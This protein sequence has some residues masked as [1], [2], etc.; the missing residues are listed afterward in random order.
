MAPSKKQKPHNPAT[1]AVHGG[2]PKREP[3]DPV[4][5]PLVQ[6]VN[7]V[8]Y[9]NTAEGLRYTRYGNTPNEE[10]V[11]KR[12][13]LLEGAEAA[14]VLSSGMGATACALLT[15]LRPGDHLLSSSWIYGGTRRLFDE[16]FVQMG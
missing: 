2:L 1:I 8:Q 14:L 16:E 13:A 4:S 6:S 10:V 3:G 11:Q 7:Y 5:M 9:P 15:L 12:I